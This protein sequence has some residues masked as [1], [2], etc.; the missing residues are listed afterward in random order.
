MN[1]ELVYF[2]GK[3][4]K[5]RP[6]HV[7]VRLNYERVINYVRIVKSENSVAEILKI[8]GKSGRI[9]SSESLNQLEKGGMYYGL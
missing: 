1:Y 5:F 4:K 6:N 2:Q 8:V 9:N 7:F 3:N